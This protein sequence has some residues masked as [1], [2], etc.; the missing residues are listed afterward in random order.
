MPR[1]VGDV[2]PP[3]E[4]AAGGR[5]REAKRAELE[6]LRRETAEKNK[7]VRELEME[8]DVLAAAI[9]QIFENS[10]GTYGSPKIWLALV[11]QGRRVWGNSIAR[12]TAELG[13]VVDEPEHRR[14]RRGGLRGVCGRLGVLEAAPPD[15]VDP[16][17]VLRRV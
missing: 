14:T 3:A 9:K 17:V 4:A 2:C 11:R 6:R 12:L 1:R 13:L 10:K 7:R 5:M 16:L 8:C 15:D